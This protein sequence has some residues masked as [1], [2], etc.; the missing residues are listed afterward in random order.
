MKK[1]IIIY[2]KSRGFKPGDF[3]PCEKCGM[4]AVDIHHIEERGM[5]G[6][7]S[8]DVEWNLVALC[9]KEHDLYWTQDMKEWLNDLKERNKVKYKET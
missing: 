8:R 5:G 7:K 2:L 3:I 9:R 6:R 4:E 1:H